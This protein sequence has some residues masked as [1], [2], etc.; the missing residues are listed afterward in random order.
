MNKEEILAKSRAENKGTDEREKLVLAKAGQKAFGVGLILSMLITMFNGI[1]GEINAEL[2][3]PKLTS[4][5]WGIYLSMM[6]ALFLYKYIKLKRKHELILSIFF[7]LVGIAAL[8]VL[9]LQM[10]GVL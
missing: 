6:G 7:L 9:A 8:V 4:G 3:D 10:L 1:L 2:Y 5:P